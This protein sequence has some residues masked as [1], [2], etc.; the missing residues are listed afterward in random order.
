MPTTG[1]AGN[2][3]SRSVGT[4]SGTDREVRDDA[5]WPSADRINALNQV[6]RDGV[7]PAGGPSTTWRYAYDL[8]GNLVSRT[9]GT[10]TWSHSWD[11]DDHLVQVTLPG[12]VTVAYAYDMA[13]R[14]LRRTHSVAGTTTFKW[15]G[16]DC[17]REVSPDQVVTRWGT[18]QGWLLWFE[19]GGARYEVH[20]D[21]LG[22]VRMGTGCDGAALARFDDDARGTPLPSA[23][24]HVPGGMPYRFVGALGVRWDEGIGLHYMRQRWYDP[25]LGRFIS[26]DPLLE[27]G[28]QVYQDSQN[29]PIVLVDAFGEKAGQPYVSGDTAAIQALKEIAARTRSESTEYGGFAYSC[30]GDNGKTVC[31]YSEV[32]RPPIGHNVSPPVFRQRGLGVRSF[33]RIGTRN[34]WQDRMCVHGIVCDS[35]HKK[36]PGTNIVAMYHSH[37]Y[38]EGYTIEDFSTGVNSDLAARMGLMLP[39][40]LPTSSGHIKCADVTVTAVRKSRTWGRSVWTI[41]YRHPGYR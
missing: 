28:S 9:D 36:N 22:S 5:S 26:R 12:G 19:R 21:T 39:G 31:S 40:Y 7:T 33:R 23:F 8:D 2:M 11:E 29:N 3:V 38:F 34:P 32:V 1:P 27:T 41:R 17:V 15:D 20:S 37:L 10:R 24:D 14:M 13:G 16:W 25:G 4:S 18:P 30:T 35:W 6:M